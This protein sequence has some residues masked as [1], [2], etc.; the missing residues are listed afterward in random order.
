MSGR[1]TRNSWWIRYLL[2]VHLMAVAASIVLLGPSL[3]DVGASRALSALG[4]SA[5][6]FVPLF[7]IGASSARLGSGSVLRICDW[8]LHGFWIA[9][10]LVSSIQGWGPFAFRPQPM[11]GS[12]ES[13]ASLEARHNWVVAIRL[14]VL[15]G[16]YSG[17]PIGL[18]LVARC[19][20]SPADS[21]RTRLPKIL[22]MASFAA[23]VL[24]SL[25][26]RYVWHGSEWV[27]GSVVAILL[28]ISFCIAAFF[29]AGGDSAW[30]RILLCEAGL[31]GLLRLV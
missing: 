23:A 21:E 9:L 13:L 27:A 8:T 25:L 6:F 15:S 17:I 16:L 10:M 22:S 5:A 20:Y 24:A 7:A 18:S 29:A 30:A 31:F 19:K 14:V 1:F 2:L 3:R 11:P 26:L 12:I 28:I 4:S